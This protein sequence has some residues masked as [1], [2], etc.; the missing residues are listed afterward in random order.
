VSGAWLLEYCGVA[1]AAN[2]HDELPLS[3][4]EANALFAAGYRSYREFEAVLIRWLPNWRAEEFAKYLLGMPGR[5]KGSF[6]AW[7]VFDTPSRRMAVLA[8]LI[9]VEL[10]REVLF[11]YPATSKYRS[12]HIFCP[13]VAVDGSAPCHRVG[14]VWPCCHATLTPPEAESAHCVRCISA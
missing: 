9:A 12:S 10:P 8:K 13:L 5:E 11:G 2:M 7:I 3:P 14:W 4:L 6:N 1:F